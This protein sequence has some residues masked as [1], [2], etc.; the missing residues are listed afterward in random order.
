MKKIPVLID[1]NLTEDFAA[2]MF[3]AAGAETID[4]LGISL[5]F[6]ETD[7]ACAAGNTAGLL[8]F[9]GLDVP[10]ALGADKPWRRDYMIPMKSMPLNR[11]INGLQVNVKAP[12][13]VAPEFA[14]DFLYEMMKGQ[15]EKV[16][17]LCAGPLTNIAY[18]LDRHPDAKEYID[19]LIWRGGTQRH[20]VLDSV[21]D[22]QTYLD[23]E[24]VD[25]VLSQG[26]N[27][28]LCPVDLGFKLYARQ[29][30]IDAGMK[31]ANPVL[32]QYNRLLKKRWCEANEDA[33]MELRNRPLPL[34][35]LA[36]VMYLT[37][38]EWFLGRRLYAEVD[39]KG[40]LTFGMLVIDINNRLEKEES[41]F[42]IYLLTDVDRE[43]AVS[44]LYQ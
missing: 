7:L 31:S 12:M 27:L 24:A 26:L 8:E 38:P 32:H 20:A 1:M 25:F 5:C 15:K 42:N 33:P 11:N 16:V 23:P 39:R 29:D 41:E 40:T 6:G 28:V 18:L 17:L 21:K 9:L 43:S 22:M 19:R 10:V 35:E 30:E 3:A 36:S 2:A 14:P 34:Q 13:K 44:H 37:N 4:I